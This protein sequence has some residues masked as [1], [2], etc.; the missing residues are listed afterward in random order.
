MARCHLLHEV[1]GV[2]H[3]VSMYSEGVYCLTEEDEGALPVYYNS[4]TFDVV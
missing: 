3:S 4:F 1:S 2:L